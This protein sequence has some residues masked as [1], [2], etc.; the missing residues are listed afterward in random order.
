[1]KRGVARTIR[2]A[3]D[4]SLDRGLR[5]GARQRKVRAPDPDQQAK[6]RCGG[7]PPQQHPAVVFFLAE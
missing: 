5:R 3:Q 6:N 4:M 2:I 7:R 1:M